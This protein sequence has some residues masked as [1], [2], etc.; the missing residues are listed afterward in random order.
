MPTSGNA[1]LRGLKGGECPYLMTLRDLPDLTNNPR[2]G[3]APQDGS[4]EMVWISPPPFPDKETAGL[5]HK[6]IATESGATTARC[7]EVVHTALTAMRPGPDELAALRPIAGRCAM[8]HALKLPTRSIR[9]GFTSHI[10]P[11]E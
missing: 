5:P 3:E 2:R 8:N 10:Q 1:P 11:A 6:P 4:R 7:T 9:T